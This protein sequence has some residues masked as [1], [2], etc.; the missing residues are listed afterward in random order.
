L[1]I[2]GRIISRRVTLQNSRLLDHAREVRD[3][4]FIDGRRLGVV[5]RIFGTPRPISNVRKRGRMPHIKRG[6]AVS[7]TDMA[8]FFSPSPKVG[9]WSQNYCE[10]S[11]REI[12]NGSPGWAASKQQIQWLSGKWVTKGLRIASVFI[13]MIFGM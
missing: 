5:C 2:L 9:Q 6:E 13:A 10:V 1:S 11:M 12:S 3:R 4:L 8:H 7:G